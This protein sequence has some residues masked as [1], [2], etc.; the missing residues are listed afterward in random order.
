M[1]AIHAKNQMNPG[2]LTH[3]ILLPVASRSDI[4]VEQEEGGL[5]LQELFSG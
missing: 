4:A 3:L 2:S 5:Q 1:I